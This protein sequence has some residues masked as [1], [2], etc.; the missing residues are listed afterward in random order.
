[1]TKPVV[2]YTWDCSNCEFTY[3]SPTVIAGISHLCKDRKRRLL[4]LV[5]T[6]DPRGVGGDSS[7]EVGDYRARP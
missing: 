4:R 5:T 7:L 6:A 2:Y 3:E 1:M